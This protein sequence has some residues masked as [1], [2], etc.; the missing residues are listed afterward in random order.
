[1][2]SAHGIYHD[3]KGSPF[4]IGDRILVSK[5]TDDTFSQEHLGEN[6]IIIYFEYSC[7]CGQSFPHD[8]MIAIRF[9]D[10]TVDEFW[11]EEID[12]LAAENR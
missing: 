4:R 9:P 3:V 10:G 1:M 12:Y 2:G 11:K 7:G 6:G 8:P 5:G